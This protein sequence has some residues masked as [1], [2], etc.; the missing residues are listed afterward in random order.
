M[1]AFVVVG[2]AFVVVG[3]VV[4]VSPLLFIA[5]DDVAGVDDFPVEGVR[6]FGDSMIS[7]AI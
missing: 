3:D 7:D 5:E 2:D 4:L 1:D 6:A